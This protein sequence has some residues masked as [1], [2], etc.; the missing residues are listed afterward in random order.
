MYRI[1]YPLAFGVTGKD[2]WLPAGCRRVGGKDGLELDGHCDDMRRDSGVWYAQSTL[3]RT[4]C[5]CSL[6]DKRNETK[7]VL[8]CKKEF[9]FAIL[10]RM[11]MPWC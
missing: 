10:V 2:C 6:K 8:G 7:R 3:A 4:C 5:A 1:G 11:S 9:V